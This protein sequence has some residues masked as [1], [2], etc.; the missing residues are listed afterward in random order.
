[1]MNFNVYVDEQTGKLLA[2]LAKERH[3]SRNA[4]IREAVANLLQRD[5]QADWP[6]SVRDFPGIPNSPAFEAARQAL[7]APPKDPV[8]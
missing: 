4:L 2:R 1:M 8:A 3:V 5:T 6:Q 7:R